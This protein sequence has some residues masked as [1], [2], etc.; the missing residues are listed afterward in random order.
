MLFVDGRYTL[1]A[2]KQS[3][4]K[5]KIFEIT[6]SLPHKI[7][8][9]KKLKIGYNPLFFTSRMLD[10]YFKKK[11]NLVAVNKDLVKVNKK[12]SSKSKFY[13]LDSKITGE[14][15]IQKKRKLIKILKKNKSYAI[16]ISAP[17]NVAWL[18]NIRG[19]DNPFS[20]IP[21]SKLILNVKGQTFLFSDKFKSKN[22]AGKILPKNMIFDE[23]SI[24]YFLKSFDKRKVIIDKNSC[25]IKYEKILK[26]ISN[27]NDPIYFLKSLK[28]KKE[29]LNM[30]SAHILDG[31]AVTK[32]LFWLKN[33]KYKKLT[34]LSAQKKLENLRKRNKKY[35]YP[36]FNTISAAGENG[37][38]VHY[39]AK[40]NSYRKI[41]KQDIYLCDSGGQYKYGTTDVTRTISFKD[42]S[43]KIKNI[44]TKVLKGHIAVVTADLSKKT[45][46]QKLDKLARK[47]LKKDK[48]DYKHGTGHGVGFFLNVHEGP[49]SISKNNSVPISEGMILS[50]EPGYYKKGSFGIRI[51]NLIYVKKYNNKL[52]FENLTLVPIDSDLINFKKLSKN[53][54][55]YLINY[56]LKVYEKLKNFLTPKEK[57]WLLRSI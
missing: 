43:E 30:I 44:F 1:Q 5:F 17:E 2:L 31:V 55:I 38:I 57:S 9:N 11:V 23:S 35:L 32:F 37:A 16:F 22:I 33:K 39:R 46:G 54:K 50:N 8:K 41:K 10:F 15:Y 25:S 14:S 47:F 34:E 13:N 20:P 19:R 52:K 3:G 26:N 45:S 29:I 24:E 4:K 27:L 21:N 51:E 18:L 56:H 40:K 12:F 28:N 42:Q 6:H 49:Q 53:E 7:I 48:L 36:S